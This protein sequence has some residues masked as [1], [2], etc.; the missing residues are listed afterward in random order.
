MIVTLHKENMI[1]MEKYKEFADDLGV[2]YSFSIFTVEPD[3]AL[4]QDYILSNNDLLFIEK[5]LMELNGEVNLQ[6]FPVN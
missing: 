4:F 6:D 3:N 5:K 2:T 1:Y